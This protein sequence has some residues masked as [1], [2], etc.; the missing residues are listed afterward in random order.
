VEW[1]TQP[2]RD[3][4]T[5]QRSSAGQMICTEIGPNTVEAIV[6]VAAFASIAIMIATIAIFKGWEHYV[7]EKY[8]RR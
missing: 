5:R 4:A 6:A 8:K 3:R 2:N 1:P 7:T